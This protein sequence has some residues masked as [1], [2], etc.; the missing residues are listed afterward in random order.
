[1]SAKPVCFGRPSRFDYTARRSS[2]DIVTGR[3][4]VTG[5]AGY[6]GK[7]LRQPPPPPASSPDKHRVQKD[8]QGTLARQ[9]APFG[10]DPAET[11]ALQARIDL[12]YAAPGERKF[13]PVSL[14]TVV[15]RGEKPR[16]RP[17]AE[18]LGGER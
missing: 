16:A 7:A 3:T 17:L 1:M 9:Q 5:Q 13:A 8:R 6:R 2:G 10:V 14:S 4:E 11:A 12:D 18:L 15:K